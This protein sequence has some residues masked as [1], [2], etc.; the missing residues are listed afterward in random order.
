MIGTMIE[1]TLTR[2]STAPIETVF[3]AMTDHCRI[4]EYMRICRRSTL[5]REGTPA[6]N[7]VGAIRRLETIGA[8]FV[9]EIIEYQRPTRY[10]YKM[11][12][13]MPT[14]DHVGTVELREAGTGTEISWHLR[15]TL[16]IPGIDRLMLPVAKAVIAEL[17]S[18]GINA[19][20]RDIS[21]PAAAL[22]TADDRFF[23]TA[24]FVLPATIDLPHSPAQVWDAL[25]DDRLGAWMPIVDRARW[26]DPAPRSRGARRTIRLLRRVTI[27]EEF[28]I[29]EEGRRIAFRALDIRPR[30]ASGWAEQAELDPLPGGGTRL[31]Y[32]IAVN[33][34][35]LR[36]VPIPG[37]LT[38]AAAAASRQMLRGITTVLPPPAPDAEP[39]SP[40]PP[41]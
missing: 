1:F 10:A 30:I 20:E 22:T 7:G 3:E 24:D 5:D 35:M 15:S 26:I 21:Q 6:P 14:R 36:P 13:G 38:P 41:R 23:T 39:T 28:H 17:L 33:A 9:E 37:F 40:R 8:P 32:T 19:A 34:R 12:S 2:T 25:T 31:T 18:G 29:W 11:I 27:D 4:S 16:K